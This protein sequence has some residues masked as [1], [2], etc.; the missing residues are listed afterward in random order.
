[1]KEKYSAV[2]LAAGKGTRMGRDTEKQYLMLGKKPLLVHA[3]ETF[4]Q[5]ELIHQIILVADQ[6]HVAWCREAVV[7]PFGL[8][9]VTA[10]LAGGKERYDSVWN[11]LSYLVSAESRINSSEEN[12][13]YVLIHDGARPF[14]SVP[15]IER[16]CAE[17]KTKKACVAG[18]PVKDTIKLVSA[19]GVITESPERSMVWQA[20]TPQAFSLELIVQAFTKQREEGF[21]GITDDGMIVEKQMKVPVFMTVGSDQNIKITTPEDLVIAEAFL[22]AFF[23]KK[24]V[25]RCMGS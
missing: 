19:G 4:Q 9:K 2:V 24:V 18:M 12:G 3:L 20:Q 22:E 15:M 1:M 5:C 25:D 14:V 10:V 13:E 7:E 8:N 11:A 16:I 17:V 23:C 6:A 21:L